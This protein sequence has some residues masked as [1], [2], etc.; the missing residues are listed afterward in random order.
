M[1][2]A[3]SCYE[4]LSRCQVRG[5]DYR[6]RLFRGSSGIAV[7]AIHGGGIEPGTTE[8]A[9]ALAAGGHSFYTFSGLK[10][11]G[12][13]DLHITSRQFDEPG[14]AALAAQ[15]RTVLTIHG[16]KEGEPLVYIGGRDDRLKQILK[17]SLQRAGFKVEQTPRFPGRH[18]RNICNRCR[19][20]RGVQLEI[21]AGLRRSLFDDLARRGRKKKMTPRFFEFI[22]AVQEALRVGRPPDRSIGSKTAPGESIAESIS[23]SN[24]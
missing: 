19:S 10:P 11:S 4:D 24:V 9:E 14:G 8:I 6:I 3:Y 17:R 20:G 1:P 18:P 21:S 7:M 15:A 5:E 23:D 16:C 13:A 12:N 2:D 22:A